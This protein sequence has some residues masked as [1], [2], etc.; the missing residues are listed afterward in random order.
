MLVLH[1][2]SYKSSIQALRLWTPSHSPLKTKNLKQFITAQKHKYT[3]CNNNRR[4][5]Q[6]FD[7]DAFMHTFVYNCLCL[8]RWT[9]WSKEARDRIL[10]MLSGIGW[11]HLVSQVIFTPIGFVDYLKVT[12]IILLTAWDALSRRV[13]NSFYLS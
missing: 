10:R 11:R 4:S 8:C 3:K 12:D 6:K 7:I 1:Q 9:P 2:L 5:T 13:L